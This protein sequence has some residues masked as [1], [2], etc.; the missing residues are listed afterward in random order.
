MRTSSIRKAVINITRLLSTS[1]V[2]EHYGRG[3]ELLN[4]ILKEL[5]KIGT[6]DK[7]TIDDLAP[8]DEFHVGGREATKDFLERLD[9]FEKHR[10]LDV[11]SGIAGPARFVASHFGCKVTGIDL[12]PEFISCGK[13]LTRMVGLENKVELVEGSALDL[14]ATFSGT[15]QL[16]DRAYML[17]VGMN[18]ED[19]P[20]LLS[21]I[22]A[23]LRP[24]G[25]LGIYDVMKYG[26]NAT[27]DLDFPVPWAR[28]ADANFIASPE[29]YRNAIKL[30]GLKLISERNRLEF[31]MEFFSKLKKKQNTSAIGLHLI[32]DDFPQKMGNMIVNL[33]RGRISP[34]EMIA[35][36]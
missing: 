14:T 34:I 18:I 3:G 17:H 7:I 16:F 15:D 12:T 29:E 32:M 6:L 33:N 26:K 30:A 11:G 21:E 5:R 1:V 20:L 9:I 28:T 2:P 35:V 4:T 19:K 10:V 13:E 23:I 24:G 36:K 31:A 22:A 8:M 25:M 27:Q